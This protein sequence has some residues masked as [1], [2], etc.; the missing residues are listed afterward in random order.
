MLKISNKKR[1]F[2]TVKRVVDN[3]P[4]I[5]LRSSQCYFHLLKAGISDGISSATGIYDDVPGDVPDV[6]NPNM[7]KLDL[8][9]ALLRSGAGTKTA[10]KVAEDGV[11]SNVD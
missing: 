2:V 10:S 8:A 4:Q 1:N 3:P 5:V 7:D 6:F 9:H 11:S